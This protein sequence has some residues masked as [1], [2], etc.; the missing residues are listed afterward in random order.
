MT[1]FFFA[2]ATLA[3]IYA[4][5]S[6]VTDFDADFRVSAIAA[7]LALGAFFFSREPGRL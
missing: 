3:T 7:M 5:A 4:A 2:L 6:Y 1:R